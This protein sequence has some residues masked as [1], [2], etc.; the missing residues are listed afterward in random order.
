MKKLKET[1][2]NSNLKLVN[3]LKRGKT[4]FHD[5]FELVFDWLN[6]VA[7]VFLT[8]HTVK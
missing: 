3:S 4:R 7:R 1:N 5:W 8:N 2:E 6:K